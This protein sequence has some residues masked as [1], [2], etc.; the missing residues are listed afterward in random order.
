MYY[1]CSKYFVHL[2]LVLFGESK[3]FLIV[4]IS[5]LTVSVFCVHQTHSNS[6]LDVGACSE[7]KNMY[8]TKKPCV[9]SIHGVP[10]KTYCTGIYN[11]GIKWNEF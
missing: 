5:K 2:I 11:P 8:D 10:S 1:V 3:N 4:K 7:G 6:Y 9:L